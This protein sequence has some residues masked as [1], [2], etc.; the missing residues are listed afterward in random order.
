MFQFTV[1]GMTCGGC[2]R[3]VTTAILSV[4]PAAEVITDPPARDVK[5]TTGA[6]EKALVA[7]LAGAGYPA[8]RK[9]QAATT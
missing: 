2:A 4:D 8:E 7:A 6:D 5:V 1:P 9:H 3:R